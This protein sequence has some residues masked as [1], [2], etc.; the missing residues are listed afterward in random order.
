MAAKDN[1]MSHQGRG[2]N[3]AVGPYVVQ[4]VALSL[5]AHWKKKKMTLGNTGIVEISMCTYTCRNDSKAINT[6]IYLL[7]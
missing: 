5:L 1:L 7:R 6:A 3:A 2:S 4:V